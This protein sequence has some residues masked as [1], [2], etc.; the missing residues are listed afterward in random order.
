[1]AEV[2]ITGGS[3]G[4][5]FELAKCFAEDGYDVILAARSM[6]KLFDAKNELQQ[7]YQVHVDIISIDLSVPGAAEE[8]YEKV[9]GRNI[10]ALVN[11]AGSGYTGISWQ[12]DIEAA[13]KMITLNNTALMSMTLLMLRDF[14][15]K[16]SGTILNVASTGAFQPGAYIAGYYAAKAFV[17]HFT[18]A[19][20]EEAEPYGV[21]VCCVCP[22]PVDTDFYRK[23]GVSKPKFAMS[24]EKTARETYRKMK[25]GMTVIIPGASNRLVTHLPKGIRKGY[26]KRSKIK[27]LEKTKKAK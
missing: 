10:D 11:N 21:Q 17:L 8:L 27:V 6:V 14:T 16:G 3:E 5:G 20:A 9:K 12:Q 26:V 2:L 1:M 19:V 23:S 13:E 7:Q 15:A 25:K 24:A 4:I 18:E 22:G